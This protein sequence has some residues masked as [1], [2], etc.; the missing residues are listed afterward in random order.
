MTHPTK[1]HVLDALDTATPIVVPKGI[2]GF[3]FGDHLRHL[4]EHAAPFQQRWTSSVGAFTASAAAGSN[5]TL[6]RYSDVVL[7]P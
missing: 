1:R 5:W 7:V 3:T 6:K 2:D 4:A